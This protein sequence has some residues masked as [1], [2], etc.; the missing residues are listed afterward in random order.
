MLTAGRLGPPATALG[1]H[2]GVVAAY[3]TSGK[4]LTG[5]VRMAIDSPLLGFHRLETAA[6]MPV[7]LQVMQLRFE[8]RDLA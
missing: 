6:V 5:G 7:T 4:A 2:V 8:R 1:A 3:G